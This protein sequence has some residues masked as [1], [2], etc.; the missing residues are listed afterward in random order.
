[1]AALATP[2]LSVFPL[3]SLG[4]EVRVCISFLS[5]VVAL[6]SND[7]AELRALLLGTLAHYIN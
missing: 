2:L 5:P 6:V 3:D 7:R 4:P 1:M